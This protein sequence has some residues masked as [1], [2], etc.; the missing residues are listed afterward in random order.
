[1]GNKSTS[2]HRT[3][4]DFEVIPTAEA[5]L[6]DIPIGSAYNIEVILPSAPPMPFN[7]ATTCVK[8]IEDNNTLDA[9]A[10]EPSAPPMPTELLPLHDQF[11]THSDDTGLDRC[12]IGRYP[13]DYFNNSNER[14]LREGIDRTYVALVRCVLESGELDSINILTREFDYLNQ[15]ISRSKHNKRRLQIKNMLE[16]RMKIALK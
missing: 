13:K 10:P 16:E 9:F 4:F 3:S 1:M 6:L 8:F 11:K 7:E 14:A 2:N 5:V 12:G 15:R